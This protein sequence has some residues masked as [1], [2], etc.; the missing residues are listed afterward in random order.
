MNTKQ[1]VILGRITTA[2]AIG[3]PIMTLPQLIEV[4]AG[5]TAGVSLLT[6]SMYTL[7]SLIF[8]IYGVVTREKILMIAY[9]PMFIIE[10]GIIAGL[11]MN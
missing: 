1:K 2:A 8:A 5:N 4:F 7:M 6:W 3:M 9:I 11:L 10:V